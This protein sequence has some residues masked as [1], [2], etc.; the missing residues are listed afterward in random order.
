MTE[1]EFD[2]F[3]AEAVHR[4]GLPTVARYLIAASEDLGW[5]IPR[6]HRKLVI[7]GLVLL[8]RAVEGKATR[9]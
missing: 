7:T 5:P 9:H 6:R 1:Y 2:Q 4:I 8:I 3:F